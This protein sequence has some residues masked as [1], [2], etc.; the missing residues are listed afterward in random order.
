[1]LSYFIVKN[2]CF[3]GYCGKLPVRPKVVLIATHAD[4]VKCPKNSRGEHVATDNIYTVYNR[5]RE[6]FGSDIELVDR[7]FIIDAHVASSHDMKAVKH[8]LYEIKSH[9]S[10]VP[11]FIFYSIQ[12]QILV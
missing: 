7:I 6:M 9:I 12:I 11:V 5:A 8:Q 3:L 4:K 1:M 10:K 2:L